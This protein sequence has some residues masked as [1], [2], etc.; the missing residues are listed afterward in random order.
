MKKHP[1]IL[2]IIF[3]TLL[4]SIVW[5]FTP[6]EYT[7]VTKI[8]DEYKEMDIA[9]GLSQIQ[10]TIKGILGSGNEGIN[11]MESYCKILRSEDFVRTISHKQV[12]HKGLS[13]GE[14]LNKKDTI[15][16]IQEHINYNY[17]SKNEVLTISFTDNN[18]LIAA[19]MT[20]RL[21]GKETQAASRGIPRAARP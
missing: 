10:A 4:A 14:Y 21:S 3:A 1:Y 6:K 12:P 20:G 7:A 17:S 8:A 15:E 11:D 9:I 16:V 2:T 5:L 19:Q 18:A 13:Y